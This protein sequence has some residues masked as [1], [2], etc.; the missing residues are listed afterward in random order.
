MLSFSSKPTDLQAKLDAI[1]RSQAVIEFETDGTIIEANE[2]FLGALGYKLEEIQG[3]HHRM[4]VEKE[5]ANSNEYQQFWR[6]LAT[7]KFRSGEFKRFT[8]NGDEIWIQ[9]SYNPLFDKD[10]NVL[11]S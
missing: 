2:N 1:S 10:G 7:G 3:K 9:A 5:E 11:K 4:F 8:K 6:T